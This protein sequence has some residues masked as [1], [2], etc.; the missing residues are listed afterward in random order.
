MARQRVSRSLRL[1]LGTGGVEG[2]ADGALFPKLLS[3]AKEKSS[4]NLPAI[5]PY[6]EGDEECGAGCSGTA[7]DTGRSPGRAVTYLH[8]HP[9]DKKQDVL[10]ILYVSFTHSKSIYSMLSVCQ[11]LLS[12]LGIHRIAHV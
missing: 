4:S 9:V 10:E 1:I 6:Q 2:L 8:R 12:Q 7:G 3:P 11:T 5:H